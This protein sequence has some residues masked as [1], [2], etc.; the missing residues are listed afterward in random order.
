MVKQCGQNEGFK[1]SSLEKPELWSLNYFA[2]DSAHCLCPFANFSTRS[3]SPRSKNELSH[4][5]RGEKGI[6]SFRSGFNTS[7]FL[8]PPVPFCGT[9]D[10]KRCYNHPQHM[11]LPFATTLLKNLVG[12]L[13]SLP[14]PFVSLLLI[15]LLFCSTSP[16][17]ETFCL[18]HFVLSDKLNFWKK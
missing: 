7:T 6:K 5:G 14:P 16:P 3:K 4:G 8:F 17:R 15:L 18:F 13:T 10:G 1:F 11:I 12:H 9:Y 2:E